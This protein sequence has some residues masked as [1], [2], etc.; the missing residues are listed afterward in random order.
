MVFHEI[1]KEAISKAI[2]TREIDMELVHAQETRR[3]LDRLVGYTLSPLLWKKFLGVYL[4]K[5]SIS[6]SKIACFR[7]RARDL[8]KVEVRT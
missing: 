2:K 1:T 3:I 5:S 4:L 7:E 8:S 6:C